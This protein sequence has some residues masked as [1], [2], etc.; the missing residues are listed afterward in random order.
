LLLV[1]FFPGG[2]QKPINEASFLSILF[3]FG[4]S[5]KTKISHNQSYPIQLLKG[6]ALWIFFIATLPALVGI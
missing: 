3:I 6:I 4:K 1:K 5:N 2:I